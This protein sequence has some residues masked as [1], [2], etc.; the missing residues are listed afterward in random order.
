MLFLS[1]MKLAITSRKKNEL[2]PKGES[3]TFSRVPTLS[4]NSITEWT[5]QNGRVSTFST[6]HRDPKMKIIQ[7]VLPPSGL[8]SKIANIFQLT[9]LNAE[10]LIVH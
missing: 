10:H 1:F 3:F 5:N 2:K 6:V 9:F 7:I 4:N 8:R